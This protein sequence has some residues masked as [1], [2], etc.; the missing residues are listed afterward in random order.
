MYASNCLP[1]EKDMPSKETMV[2]HRK[3]QQIP[4]FSLILGIGIVHRPRQKRRIEMGA[5]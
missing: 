5:E 1:L 2:F 4:S 3:I